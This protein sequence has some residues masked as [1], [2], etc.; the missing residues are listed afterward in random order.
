[1]HQAC[2]LSIQKQSFV[3]LGQIPLP[4]FPG[5]LPLLSLPLSS[6]FVHY[7]CP[8]SLWDEYIYFVLRTWSWSSWA[9]TVSFPWGPRVSTEAPSIAFH[10]LLLKSLPPPD[11]SKS[12]W[13][14]RSVWNPLQEPIQCS[15]LDRIIWAEQSVWILSIKFL[16]APKSKCSI[17]S[18]LL[19]LLE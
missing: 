10:I 19:L 2:L 1:M 3:P 14:F 16:W 18:K 13:I 17:N 12:W 9:S 4:S 8:L 15:M 5:S 11:F 6:V 7:P